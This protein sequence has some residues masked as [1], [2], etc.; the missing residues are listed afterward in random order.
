MRYEHKIVIKREELYERIWQIPARQLAKELELSDVR[1][2]VICRMLKVPKPG[3]GYWA[4]FSHGKHP[5]R[6]PLPQIGPEEKSEFVHIVDDDRKRTMEIDPAIK[7]LLDN[8][9][10][11]EV[12]TRLTNPDPL[13]RN[14]RAWLRKRPYQYSESARLPHLSL[15][16]YP[17]STDRALLLMDALVKGIKKLGYGVRGE[18][19]SNRDQYFE[20][21]DQ[22]IQFQLKERTKQID[23]VLTKEEQARKAQGREIFASKYDY[24]PTGLFE[25]IL[26]PGIWIGPSYK[27]KWSD[28][29]KKPLESQLRDI[30]RGLILIADGQRKEA[31]KQK[32][33][34][35]VTAEQRMIR[36][37]EEKKLAE[38]EAR[39]KAT[40]NHVANWV[41][42]R[43]LRAFIREFE[44]RL[45]AGPYTEQVKSD[46]QTWIRWANEYARELDPITATISKLDSGIKQDK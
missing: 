37:E 32:K 5:R 43:Q 38:E 30:I 24:L 34:E 35:Q 9:P 21:L 16:V 44:R 45:M 36:I 22:R 3:P 25:L 29:I 2:T 15:N 13:V 1:L 11:I 28:S 4:K 23:H 42:S 17:D 20:I 39:R 18:D 8:V 46:Y 10:E 19:N 40:D 26:E 27:K 33:A 41:K 12:P 7:V 6:P 31:E 14:A